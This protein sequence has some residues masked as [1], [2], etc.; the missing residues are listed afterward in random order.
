MGLSGH[1]FCLV[2]P[3]SPISDIEHCFCLCTCVNEVWPHTRDII[4]GLVG[5][6]IPNDKLIR[7]NMPKSSKENEIVWLLGNLFPSHGKDYHL[8]ILL[9]EGQNSSVIYGLNSRTI[10]WEPE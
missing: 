9:S 2:C 4:V 7:Y 3:G 1:P 5:E 10:K 8:V 6:D